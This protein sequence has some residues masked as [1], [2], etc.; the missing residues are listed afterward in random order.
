MT[1]RTKTRDIETLLYCLGA[2]FIVLAYAVAAAYVI[3]KG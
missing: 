3:Y 1:H 2:M